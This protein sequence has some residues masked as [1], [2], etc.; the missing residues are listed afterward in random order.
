ML[1]I[2]QQCG[3]LFFEEFADFFFPVRDDGAEEESCDGG[4]V[5]GIFCYADG[6]GST[7]GPGRQ[8]VVGGCFVVGENGVSD[9]VEV[10]L[11]CELVDVVFESPYKDSLCFMLSNPQKPKTISGSLPYKIW[12]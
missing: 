3:F 9:K 5:L 12:F 1:G 7:K 10:V 4:N 6:A 8:S 2:L 11:F